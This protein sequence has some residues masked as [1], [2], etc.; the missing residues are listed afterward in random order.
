MTLLTNSFIGFKEDSFR[1]YQKKVLTYAEEN[2][3]DL[4]NNEEFEKHVLEDFSKKNHG[5]L[6]FYLPHEFGGCGD[7]HK[8]EL[9]GLFNRYSP[10]MDLARIQPRWTNKHEFTIDLPHNPALDQVD[11]EPPEDLE[12]V[13]P[14]L[15]LA[16]IATNSDRLKYAQLFPKTV[17]QQFQENI[18]PALLDRLMKA[19]ALRT[20]ALQKH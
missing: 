5:T 15:K 6:N 16:S 20:D 11:D 13:S 14:T 12:P 7:P 1:E 9:Y 17:T 8:L 10:E 4:K 3:T 18:E 19:E 2:L